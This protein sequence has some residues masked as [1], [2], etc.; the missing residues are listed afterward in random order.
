MKKKRPVIQVLRFTDRRAFPIPRILGPTFLLL[1]LLCGMLPAQ[2]L[3]L[4]DL[5]AEA[6]LNNPELSAAEARATAAR[7]RIIRVT[8]P[9]GP[10]LEVGY[11]NEG[12]S[13]YTY[14]E[15]LDAQWMFGASQTFPFPGKRPLLGDMASLEADSAEASVAAL[16]LKIVCRITETYYDLLLAHQEIGRIEDREHLLARIED[17][18]QARQTSGLGT[19]AEA[20]MAQT[21]KYLLIEK[22]TMARRTR[23]TREAMLNRAVGRPADAPLGTPVAESP[24]PF[25]YSL[26]ELTRQAL[27]RAPELV[28]MRKMS[29]AAGKRLDMAQKDAWPDLTLSAKYSARGGGDP[30]MVSLTASVP[31]PLFSDRK[32][33]AGINEADWNLKAAQQELEAVRLAITADIRNNYAMIQAAD[34]LTAL[35][36]GALIPKARQEL[37]AAQAGYAAGRVELGTV[38]AKLKSMLDYELLALQQYAEREK[39]IMR[40]KTT[41]GGLEK[42]SP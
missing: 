34:K 15:S 36:N 2:E 4:P 33:K 23:E 6:M 31:L 35:Y 27:E 13:K 1:A 42:V 14:G 25:P 21:E 37:D 8:S 28:A 3:K 24:T 9:P 5:I 10:M 17:T 29:L 12:L 38:L 30:D 11:Q 18:A 20:L 40:I 22:A 26:E 7:Q 41:V 16:K 19:Q 39:A 32:Q